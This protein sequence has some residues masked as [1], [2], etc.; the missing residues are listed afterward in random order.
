MN[1]RLASHILALLAL[2]GCERGEHKQPAPAPAPTPTATAPDP[3]TKPAPKK[4]PLPHPLF[5]SV[6]KDGK[7]TYYLGTMHIG[8]DPNTRIPDLVWAK[9]DAAPT[10]AME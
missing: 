10:F 5:W 9:L 2:T 1:L 3:W 4:D 7:T 8:V 6:E